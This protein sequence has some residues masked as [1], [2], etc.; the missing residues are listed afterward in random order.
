MPQTGPTVALPQRVYRQLVAAFATHS[1]EWIT[2][3]IQRDPQHR[4][5]MHPG[6]PFGTVFAWIWQDNPD[7]AMLFLADTLAALRDHNPVAD[8]NPRVT[9]DELLRGM[10]LALPHD[11]TGYQQMVE[12]ARREVPVYYGSDPNTP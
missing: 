5:A 12:T 3:M 8:L 2:R 10:R 9:L 4:D 11:F 1:A 6:D 7:Q